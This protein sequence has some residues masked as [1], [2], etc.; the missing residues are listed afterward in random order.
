L[1]YSIPEGGGGTIIPDSSIRAWNDAADKAH[2]HDNKSV[3]DSISSTDLTNWRDTALDVSSWFY[4]DENGY[5][6]SRNTFIGD[7]EVAAYGNGLLGDISTYNTS[8][9]D[10]SYQYI[11]NLI[12]NIPEGGGGAD[13][14]NVSVNN[15]N[16]AYNKAH[17]HNNKSILDGISDGSVSTWNSAYIDLNKWFYWNNDTSTLHT[18]FSFV[19]D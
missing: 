14:P 13:I 3:L 16:E 10:S 7:H 5:V 15:W 12:N 1:I 4:Q 2:T 19:G 8:F 18:Y 9:I 6:H 11:I 17:T